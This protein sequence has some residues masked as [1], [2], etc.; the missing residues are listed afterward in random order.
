MG[1]PCKS[2]EEGKEWNPSSAALAAGVV[3]VGSNDADHLA[4]P[5]P[6]G[7]FASPE[8]QQTSVR[9]TLGFVKVELCRS[10]F[11]DQLVIGAITICRPAPS[12]LKI[13]FAD[14]L[15]RVVQTRIVRKSPVAA[16]VG[17]VPVLP[18]DALRNGV[19]DGLKHL[20]CP[21]QFLL[22]PLPLRDVLLDSDEM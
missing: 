11:H 3:F 17:A 16:H 10:L 22:G 4:L 15:C 1:Q 21:V 12:E 5:V 18:K 19:Q 20:V 7:Q 8:P 6:R 2:A 14:N 13:T 9:P